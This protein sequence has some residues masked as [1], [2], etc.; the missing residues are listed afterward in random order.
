MIETLKALEYPTT[1]VNHV[2]NIVKIYNIMTDKLCQVIMSCNH[3]IIDE[4]AMRRVRGDNKY[5]FLRY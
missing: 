1:L 2:I 4:P 5:R 3:K